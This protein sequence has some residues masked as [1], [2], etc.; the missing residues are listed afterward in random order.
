MTRVCYRLMVVVC[1]VGLVSCSTGDGTATPNGATTVDVVM[2]EMHFTPNHFRF[3]VGEVV[4]F[5]FHNEG[6]V[7]HEAVIGDQAAQ[8]AAMAAMAAMSTTTLAPARGRSRVLGA[9]PGMGLPNLVSVEPGKVGTIVFQFA[10]PTTLLMQC[11]EAG[12]LE[13]GMT[14]TIEVVA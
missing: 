11:H 3:H 9:H 7:R 13:G 1:L 6:K 4:A 10:K 12:H 8:D 2:D 5:R 14:A